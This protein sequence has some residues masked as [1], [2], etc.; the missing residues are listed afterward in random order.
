MDLVSAT[1]LASSHSQSAFVNKVHLVP[2]PIFRK[3][4]SELK[5]NYLDYY[6]R[7]R[8]PLIDQGEECRRGVF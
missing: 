3:V 4:T 2:L 8:K 5:Q 7:H 6:L 1:P